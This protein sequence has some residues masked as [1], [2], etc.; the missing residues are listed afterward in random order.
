MTHAERYPVALALAVFF[1]V[2]FL[3]AGWPVIALAL[4]VVIAAGLLHTRGLLLPALIAV[5]IFVPNYTIFGTQPAE[6]HA[7][8]KITQDIEAG[9]LERRFAILGLFAIGALIIMM[10]GKR[11]NRTGLFRWMVGYLILAVA[12]V[13]W[14]DDLDLTL[15]RA[16]ILASILIFCFGLG[17]VYFGGR[18]DGA[19][20]LVRALSWSSAAAC[21]VVIAVSAVTGNV[22]L[23]DPS[24]RLGSEGHENQIA[25]IAAIGSLT[26][27]LTRGNKQIWL[28]RF[29][30]LC[31]LIPTASVAILTKSRT[32]LV[33]LAVAL[34][35]CGFIE[36]RRQRRV[37]TL[38]LVAAGVALLLAI[39]SGHLFWTRGASQ[40]E[41]ETLS[42]RQELWK[43]VWGE[44][45][46]S[47][48]AG[49]GYGAFWTGGTVVI[50]AGAWAPTTAHNGYLDMLAELGIL[51]L[52]MIAG[53]ALI[54]YANSRA[55]LS[56]P[57]MAYVGVVLTGLTTLFLVI[58]MGESLVQD[59]DTYP[60]IAF[61]TF[62]CLSSQLAARR[63]LATPIETR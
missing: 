22:H 49:K 38:A 20:R 31:L 12:S 40:A 28:G 1:T 48:L 26:L 19:I 58:N 50:I 2:G 34:L 43:A 45:S 29:Q 56:S 55:L 47:V 61:V 5:L 42:G 51:G 54:C 37:L 11:L 17:S 32:T 27:W 46:S 36:Y 13:T 18:P 53:F 6:S 59:I 33:A 9:S 3:A 7:V 41:L 63:S 23:F 15:R 44:A 52:G 24:W 4:C 8:S 35:V 62:A 57:S 14:S 25:Q 30:W 10:R 39:S 60:M 16:L 21:L